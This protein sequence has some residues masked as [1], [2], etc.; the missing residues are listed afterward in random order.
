MNAKEKWALLNE[1]RQQTLLNK[2]RYFE[3]EWGDWWGGVEDMLRVDMGEIGVTVASMYFSGFCS[4]GDG[5]CFNGRVFDWTRFL[6]AVKKAELAPTAVAFAFDLSWTVSGRYCHEHS[7]S[8]NLEDHLNNP[9]DSVTDSLRYYA[10]ECIY[11]TAEIAGLEELC[12]EFLRGKMRDLYSNLE[13][14]HEYLTSDEY[15]L[16]YLLE[17]E[18]GEIDLALEEQTEELEELEG[19]TK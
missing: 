9:H 7:V 17:H 6:S 11:K 5:A 10:W 18:E 14:E 1:K 13:E 2:H 15:V 16:G 19:A 12:A 4:Q 3:T 8:F